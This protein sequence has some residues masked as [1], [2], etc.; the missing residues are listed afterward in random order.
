MCKY[1]STLV[2][3]SCID[4]ITDFPEEFQ[5]SPI[6]CGECKNVL[7]LIEISKSTKK[8]LENLNVKCPSKN[9]NCFDEY[10]LKD[11]NKH[12]ENCKYWEGKSKCNSC[13]LFETNNNL[14]KHIEICKQLLIP[15]RY[16]EEKFKRKEIPKHE[17]ICPKR[18]LN[19]NRC[20]IKF[21]KNNIKIELNDHP[22][23]DNCLHYLVSE[24]SK[25]LESKILHEIFKNLT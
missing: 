22:S 8:A 16:C 24:M 6:K 11:I 21:D 1:C 14:K 2:C 15:C 7:I 3:Q 9:K 13:G 19:C 20:N 5:E 4:R 17:D 25:K 18:P 23:K 12:L 10:K